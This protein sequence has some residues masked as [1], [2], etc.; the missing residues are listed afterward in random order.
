MTD[1]GPVV[2]LVEDEPQMRRFLRVTLASHGYRV[3][4]AKT[5]EEGLA[6]AKARNPDVVLLDLGLPDYDGLHVVKSLRAWCSTPILIISA[7]GQESDKISALDAGADD[8][9]T[10]PFGAGELLA[11]IRVALR[12]AARPAQDAAAEVFAVS[13]LRVDVLGRQVHVGEREVHLTPIEFKLLTTLIRSAGKVMTHR[14]LITEVWGPAHAEQTHYLRVHMAQL[15]QKIE[16]EPARPRFLVTEP[17]IGYR[18]R[19]E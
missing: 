3:V 12:H 8:Y 2:L 5:A 7:R 17:G 13:G 4:E 18:F 16:A 6:Q 19:A 14:S 10:K 1:P 9:L 11:R 15:R